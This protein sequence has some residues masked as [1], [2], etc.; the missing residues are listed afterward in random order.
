MPNGPNGEKRSQSSVEAAVQVARIATGQK[1][2]DSP[3]GPRRVLLPNE[4]GEPVELAEIEWP[5][6]EEARRRREELRAARR[7]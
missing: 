4:S 6:R 1:P 7:R 2:N 5:T 3:R